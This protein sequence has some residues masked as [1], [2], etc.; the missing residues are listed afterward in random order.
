LLPEERFEIKFK[1]IDKDKRAIEFDK[2]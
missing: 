1:T 2:F